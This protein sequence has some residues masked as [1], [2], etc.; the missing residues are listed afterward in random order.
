MFEPDINKLSNNQEIEYVL[1]DLQNELHVDMLI[2]LKFD[3]EF[4]QVD[5][6][7]EDAVNYSELTD[8]EKNYLENN[9]TVIAEINKYPVGILQLRSGDIP[10]EVEVLTTVRPS[11]RNKGIKKLMVLSLCEYLNNI[12]VNILS[13][14][15]HK[16]NFDNLNSLKGI[17]V[18]KVSNENKEGFSKYVIYT[19]NVLYIDKLPKSR[20]K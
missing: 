18:E 16:H 17:N 14:Y 20:K 15:V 11:E 10:E 6:L 3:Y 7:I 8:E 12:G 19:D 1:C 5:F 9:F 4:K 13:F 2:E